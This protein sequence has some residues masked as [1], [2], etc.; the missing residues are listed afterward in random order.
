MCIPD[1]SL[2]DCVAA[3]KYTNFSEPVFQK[4]E[5]I[6]RMSLEELLRELTEEMSV[7]SPAKPWLDEV[8]HK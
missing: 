7:E 1:F 4:H 2:V 8:L 3:G 5:T 6:I